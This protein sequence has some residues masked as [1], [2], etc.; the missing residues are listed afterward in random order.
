MLDNIPL[1]LFFVLPHLQLEMFPDAVAGRR[2]HSRSSEAPG[3][4]GTAGDGLLLSPPAWAW[5]SLGFSCSLPHAVRFVERL[6]FVVIADLCNQLP[7]GPIWTVLIVF[8]HLTHSLSIFPFCF[9]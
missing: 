8:T 5:G 6:L 1:L 9:P 3:G 7:G 4:A 2:L